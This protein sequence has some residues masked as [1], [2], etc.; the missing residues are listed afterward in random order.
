MCCILLS[1]DMIHA[2]CKSFGPSA[3]EDLEFIV[4]RFFSTCTIPSGK[5]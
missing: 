4:Q 5:E 2:T 3:K 1:L